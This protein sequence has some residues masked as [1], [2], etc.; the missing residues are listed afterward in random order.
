MSKNTGGDGWTVIKIALTGKMRSGKTSI[1]EHLTTCYGF[2][3]FAF[4]DALKR[5]ARQIFGY[6]GP[7]DRELLQWFGQTMRERDPDVWIKH[8]D[9]DLEEYIEDS[10]GDIG[11]RIVIT[12]LRQ[13][14]EYDY[15]RRE[16]YTIIRVN[17]PEEIR[18][19]RMI[20]AGDRFDQTMLDHETERY[21]DKF[22]VDYEIDNSGRWIDMAEQVDVI[23]RELRRTGLHAL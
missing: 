10:R 19:E 15:C 16:G 23:M 6:G 18:I 4:A 3:Q 17:C 9:A 8:L 2:K 1:A 22:D 20:A 12:D 13:P 5:F 11:V 7:K 14:N 21:V